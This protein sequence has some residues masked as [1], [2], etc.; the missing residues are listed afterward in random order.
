MISDYVITFIG[1][2]MEKWIVELTIGDESMAKVKIERWI[3]KVDA[4]L[5]FLFV[6]GVMP[7]SHIR[8]KNAQ[9]DTNF[10]GCK[11]NQVPDVHRRDQ[12]AYANYEKQKTSN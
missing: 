10:I 5:Q 3:F 9:V 6:I 8:K 2:T 4:V 1:D 11:N 12:M 7:L